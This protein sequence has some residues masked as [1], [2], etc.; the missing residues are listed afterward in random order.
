MFVDQSARVRRVK[1][2]LDHWDMG[3]TSLPS[4]RRIFHR[5][6]TS[7]SFSLIPPAFA[8]RTACSFSVLNV[9]TKAD[10]NGFMAIGW[11]AY[12]EYRI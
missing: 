5:T 12:S 2:G 8:I 7:C 3:H 6:Q 4:P 10:L 11:G 1:Q 9:D